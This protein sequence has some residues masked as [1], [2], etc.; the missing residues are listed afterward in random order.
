M[1]SLMIRIDAQ[2]IGG[3]IFGSFYNSA[4]CFKKWSTRQERA[5]AM[6][7]FGECVTI[8]IVEETRDQKKGARSSRQ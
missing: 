2:P 1:M 8:R 5:Y 7:L 4:L 3:G 6:G